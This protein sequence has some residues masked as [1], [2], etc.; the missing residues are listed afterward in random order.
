MNGCIGWDLSGLDL[1]F[2]K[3]FLLGG[4]QLACFLNDRN[5]IFCNSST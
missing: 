4:N 3:R 2:Y 1:V 5:N